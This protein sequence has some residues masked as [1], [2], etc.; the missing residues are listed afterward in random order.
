MATDRVYQFTNFKD[1]KPVLDYFDAVIDSIPIMRCYIR[2]YG[3]FIC[4]NYSISKN[5]HLDIYIVF[6][7]YMTCHCNLTLENGH[8]GIFNCTRCRIVFNGFA[9]IGSFVT[10]NEKDS[11]CVIDED[12][13]FVV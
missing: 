6:P 3:D 12:E 8:I 11:A 2:D 9:S 4:Q 7:R 13:D 10:F 1:V 5:G